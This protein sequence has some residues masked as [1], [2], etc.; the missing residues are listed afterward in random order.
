VPL[1]PTVTG[2]V[3]AVPTELTGV[4]VPTVMS[5]VLLEDWATA[6]YEPVRMPSPV[7]VT[8]A[9]LAPWPSRFGETAAKDGCQKSTEPVLLWLSRL[10]MRRRCLP[11]AGTLSAAIVYEPRIWVADG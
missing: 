10:V 2:A 11:T 3:T 4:A 7:R 5:L 8:G 6:K 9:A 1:V